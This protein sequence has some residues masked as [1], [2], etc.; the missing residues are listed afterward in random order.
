MSPTPNR[1]ARARLHDAEGEHAGCVNAAS[2]GVCSFMA[3]SPVSGWRWTSRRE[4]GNEGSRSAAQGCDGSQAAAER[5]RRRGA[6]IGCGEHRVHVALVLRRGSAREGQRRRP[7]VKVEQAVAEAGLVVVVAFGLRWRRSRSGANSVRNP[8]DRANLRLG[9]LWVRQ[10]DAA[11]A[12]LDDCWRD[13]RI[14]MSARLCVAKMTLTFFLR[15]VLS[16]CRMRAANT[17]S[18]RN[19]HASSRISSGGC[20]VKAFVEARKE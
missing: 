8:V 7:Q 5:G 19:S 14:L 20:T 1:C 16:H 10:E 11:G 3:G 12:A 9:R 4:S 13:A 2:L 17:G 18:S 15:S 6:G